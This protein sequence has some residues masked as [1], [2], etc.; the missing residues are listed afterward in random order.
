[1]SPQIATSSN[2][3]PEA[4]ELKVK[5]LSK[6]MKKENPAGSPSSASQ[7]MEKTVSRWKP[8]PEVQPPEISVR[9]PGQ[10]LLSSIAKKYENHDK[11]GY[12]R[13]EDRR[14]DPRRLAQ[15][16]MDSSF[17]PLLAK[18]RGYNPLC[19]M[20]SVIVDYVRVERPEVTPLV[21]EEASPRK[22]RPLTLRQREAA[23][24]ARSQPVTST[25]S[26]HTRK[27]AAKTVPTR[28]KYHDLQIVQD[29]LHGLF[30]QDALFKAM[31]CD[32]SLAEVK[33]LLR[34]NKS[35]RQ[36]AHEVREGLA[37]P[38]RVNNY[39]DTATKLLTSTYKEAQ[40]EEERVALEQT[41][42]RRRERIAAAR[43]IAERR[44]QQRRRENNTF[45][46]FR[47]LSRV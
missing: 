12:K 43:V 32:A 3:V 30:E 29:A 19:L 35:I 31:F 47:V 14:R 34:T 41:E 42:E 36:L 16:V 2:A 1:L 23:E 28:E 18:Y 24:L 10:K 20:E 40:F 37:S 17:M 25:V 6:Q 27:G 22:K 21:E 11:V 44:E 7:V 46:P 39:L 5:R 8:R 4:S 33:Q 13:L 9:V 26:A 38:S 45:S 15:E